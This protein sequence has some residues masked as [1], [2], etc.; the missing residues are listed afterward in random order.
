[1][2]A[3]EKRLWIK[4]RV[5]G[6]ARYE[7]DYYHRVSDDI[8]SVPGNPWFIC[9][10]WLADWRIAKAKS[11]DE[12]KEALPILE[13]VASHALPSGVLAEQV[14]PES[15]A[16]LSVSPLTWSHATVVATLSAYERKWKEMSNCPTCGQS[17]VAGVH[18]QEDAADETSK[19]PA[20]L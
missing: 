20:S 5:G 4:T 3:I 17:H 12:L 7:A 18:E 2:Q 6:L 1:M 10:L 15:N 11:I 13:W 16:P 19:E 8:A 14:H 9:T